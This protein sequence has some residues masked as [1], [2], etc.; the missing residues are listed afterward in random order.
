MIKKRVSSLPIISRLLI[1]VVAFL[2][3]QAAF[4]FMLSPGGY[5]PGFELSGEPGRAVIQGMGLLFLMWNIPYLVAIIDPV[6]HFVS[7]IE[8][9]IMQSIGVFGET[10]LFLT[11]KG[12]HP[13]LESTVIRFIIFDGGG[14]IFILAAFL[15]ILFYKRSL[16]NKTI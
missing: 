13:L 5:A 10:A 4:Y 9:V 6:K 14:L 16:A 12:E 15:I 7:L 2:N 1:A 3:I 11:L 8:A